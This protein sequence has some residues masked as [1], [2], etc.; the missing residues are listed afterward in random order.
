MK[1]IISLSLI[2]CMIFLIFSACQGNADINNEPVEEEIAYDF[3]GYEYTIIGYQRFG[4]FEVGPN[5][6][7]ENTYWG[8][9]LY[10]RYRELEQKY[11]IKITVKQ[12]DGTLA[13]S[14]ATATPYADLMDTWLNTLN[15]YIK[16]DY[17]MPINGISGFEDLYSGKWGPKTTIDAVT[18]G[19]NTYG[20]RA[21]YHGIPFPTYSGI[22]YANAVVMKAFDIKPF[23]LIEQRK[24]TWDNFTD[25]CVKIGGS[26]DDPDNIVSFV[27]DDSWSDYFMRAA[28]MSN[29]VDFVKIDDDGK[30]I[31]NLDHPDAMEA[32]NWVMDFK[33]KI[34]SAVVSGEKLADPNG[35]RTFPI[36]Q[37]NKLGFVCQYSY[38]G[39]SDNVGFN[40]FDVD[41]YILP[42]PMGPK[43]E[44]GKWGSYI[45][46]ADRYFSVPITADEDVNNV[47][48][49]E[50]YKPFD[51]GTEYSWRDN[52][53]Q[54][55]FLYPESAKYF[56]EMYDNAKYDFTEITEK[57]PWQPILKGTT[58]PAEGIAK[59][60]EACQ[61]AIDTLYNN[62]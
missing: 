34:G 45:S 35:P 12:D 40:Y 4:R 60:K 20:F 2:F 26:Y 25:A 59:V 48:L 31:F 46:F 1:K 42:F 55:M 27:F 23:E 62:D 10:N 56:F 19:D 14:I 18:R 39:T 61:T 16:A 21:G 52:M 30:Y 36:F 24:W 49:K 54:N 7:E 13:S 3:N 33:Q 41:F 9:K 38:T 32:L 11:N 8:E 51:G 5:F 29:G 17:V 53:T 44:Y 43:G 47:V 22:I 37:D 58:T 15:G 28:I 6:E 50:I 57:I